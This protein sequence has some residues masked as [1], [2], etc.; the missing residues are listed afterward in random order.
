[1]SKQ[2]R[3]RVVVPALLLLL[4]FLVGFPV[5]MRSPHSFVGRFFA[6]VF[7]A[8]LIFLAIGGMVQKVALFFGWNIYDDE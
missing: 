6:Y 4:L 2:V 3:M 1:M 5:W 8:L 7:G